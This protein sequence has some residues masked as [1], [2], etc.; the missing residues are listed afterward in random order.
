M[1]TSRQVSFRSTPDINILPP[2]SITSVSSS[3][4]EPGYRI[5]DSQPTARFQKVPAMVCCS[6]CGAQVVTCIEY[7]VGSMNWALA[8]LLCALG[9]HLGCCLV[10]FFINSLKDVIHLCP[11]CRAQLGKYS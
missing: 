10:P 7:R 1:K 5:F 3:F 2:S 8:G 11:L 6:A 9:C 4:Q